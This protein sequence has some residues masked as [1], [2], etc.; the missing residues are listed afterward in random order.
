MKTQFNIE[1]AQYAKK[2]KKGYHYMRVTQF[3]SWGEPVAFWRFKSW[4]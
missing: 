4:K 1:V 2:G 3:N